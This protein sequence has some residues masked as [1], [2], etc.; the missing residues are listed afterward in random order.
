MQCS[1][2]SSERH[3][4]APDHFPTSCLVHMVTACSSHDG[5]E[6]PAGGEDLSLRF[7]HVLL[8]IPEVHPTGFEPV[9]FGF[10]DRCSI[11]LS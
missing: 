11:Q 5:L 4:L 7:N 9:T 6:C 10:V 1:L 8:R 3:R 2:A